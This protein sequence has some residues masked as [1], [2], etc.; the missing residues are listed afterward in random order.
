[1]NNKKSWIIF[2]IIF[3]S[4]IVIGLFTE[5]FAYSNSKI[6]CAKITREASVKGSKSI[7]YNFEVDGEVIEGGIGISFLKTI[8]LDSLKKIDCI[9]VEYSEY[10]TFFNRI[11]DSRILQ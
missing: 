6:T 2:I 9:R 4:I 3:S 10:S 5:K 7:Y 8:P 1:M 11:V